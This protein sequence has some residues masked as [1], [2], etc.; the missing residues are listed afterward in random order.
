MGGVGYGG[1]GLGGG[2]WGCGDV[3]LW[4]I[5]KQSVVHLTV[6]FYAKRH[7]D[8]R[9]SVIHPEIWKSMIR[10]MNNIILVTRSLIEPAWVR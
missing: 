7:P 6:D 9:N 10:F 5:S 1:L 4:Q 3:Q 8:V 2:G